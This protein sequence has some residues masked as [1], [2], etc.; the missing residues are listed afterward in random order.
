MSKQ[1]YPLTMRPGIKRDGSP[2]QSEYCTDGQWVRW[3]KGLPR[4]MGGMISPS[5]INLPLILN[6]NSTSDILVT[7]GPGQQ[8]FVFIASANNI[9]VMSTNNEFQIVSG[10]YV[11]ATPPNPNAWNDLLWQSLIIIKGGVRHLVYLGCPNKANLTNNIGQSVYLSAPLDNLFVPNPAPLTSDEFLGLD[12]VL[13]INGGMCFASPYLFLFGGNGEV[14]ISAI[15]NP[16]DFTLVAERAAGS[17]QLLSLPTGDKVIAGAQIRGGS[18]TPTILFWTLS[19]VIRLS[20]IEEDF[21]ADVISTSSSILSNKCIVEYDGIFFWPGNDRFYVYNGV[22][23]PLPNTLNNDYFFNNLN[24]TLSSKVFGVKLQRFGEAWWFFNDL[25]TNDP[26]GNLPVESRSTIC[27]SALIYNKSENSWYDTNISRSS[28]YYSPTLGTMV[29]VGS[30]VGG[31]G[32]G[33]FKHEVGVNSLFSTGN[34]RVPV[35]RPIVRSFTTPYFS[36]AAFNPLKQQMGTDHVSL[37][38]RL[39]PDFISSS[40]SLTSGGVINNPGA[41]ITVSLITYDYALSAPVV[42]QLGNIV[43]APTPPFFGGRQ[44]PNPSHSWG[45]RIAGL[46]TAAKIDAAIQGGHMQ[47]M[48][49]STDL[50]EMGHNMIQFSVGDGQR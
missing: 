36:F 27:N 6:D 39:E 33:I 14:R 22:V 28:G 42:T 43:L 20:R 1:L 25:A 35:V 50:F 40:P 49:T 7:P 31:N 37:F 24:R 32:R 8:S 9:S 38:T 19:A 29:T 17:P 15:A 47:L 48:F 44:N 2:F 41:T 12:G 23:N 26:F 21:K 5:G 34:A 46:L 4:A 13:T 30:N 10:Q 11:I 18:N 45:Q 3:Q 16:F